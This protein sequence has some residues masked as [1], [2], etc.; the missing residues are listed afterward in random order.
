MYKDVI[1]DFCFR[2]VD[3]ISV[4]RIKIVWNPNVPMLTLSQ[5]RI[6]SSQSSSYK[7]KMIMVAITYVCYTMVSSRVPMMHAEI[8]LLLLYFGLSSFFS[9]NESSSMCY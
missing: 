1:P 2:L 8:A 6:G 5:S 4:A 9:S 7:L 3:K